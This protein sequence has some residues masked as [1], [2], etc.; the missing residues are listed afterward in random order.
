ILGLGSLY[1]GDLLAGAR[2][3]KVTGKIFLVLECLNDLLIWQGS[4]SGST[5]RQSNQQYS[6]SEY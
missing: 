5:F 3:G 4:A 6:G 2:F 1:G